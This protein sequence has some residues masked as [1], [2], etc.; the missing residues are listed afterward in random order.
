MASM[1]R[2]GL[3]LY[4]RVVSRLEIAVLDIHPN[5]KN[6]PSG[7]VKIAIENDH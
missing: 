3:E 2:N 6:I 1:A 5:W 4:I 7:Y